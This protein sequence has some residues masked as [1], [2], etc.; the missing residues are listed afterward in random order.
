[1]YRCPG[2]V[3]AKAL[4]FCA[5]TDAGRGPS[6]W[7]AVGAVSTARHAVRRPQPHG[8]RHP[9]ASLLLAEGLPVTGVSRRMGH[10]NSGITMTVYAHAIGQSDEAATEA[11]RRAL[12]ADAGR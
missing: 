7:T 8:L 6:R 5:L 11:I 2:E 10:A 9:H 1:M 4:W 12:S 3:M